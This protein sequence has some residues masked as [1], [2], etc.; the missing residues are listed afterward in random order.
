MSAF[1]DAQSQHRASAAVT[2][3]TQDQTPIPTTSSSSM[4]QIIVMGRVNS[5]DTSWVEKL[6]M[7]VISAI[8]AL[9]Y[10]EC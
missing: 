9:S 7:S 8:W 6:P 3:T 2:A 5:D 4:D 1:D 10:N